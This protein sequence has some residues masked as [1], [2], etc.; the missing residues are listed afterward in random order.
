M[1]YDSGSRAE[2]RPTPVIVPLTAPFS[3]SGRYSS[4][5]LSP[6]ISGFGTST[7]TPVGV[8]QAESPS[9]IPA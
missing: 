3:R 4:C 6:V 8:A 7:L 9:T 1:P 5:S 2:S